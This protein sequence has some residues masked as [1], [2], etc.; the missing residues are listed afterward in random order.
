MNHLTVDRFLQQLHIPYE[1]ACT[2]QSE[3]ASQPTNVKTPLRQHQYA[4]LKS[5][6]TLEN[7][8]QKG[9]DLCGQTFFS[10]FG[11]LGDSVGV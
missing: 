6:E 9:Y 1:N 7:N 11:I 2:E 10:R 3:L 5:M 4:I 8:L